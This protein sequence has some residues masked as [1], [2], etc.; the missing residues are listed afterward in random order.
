MNILKSL[1]DREVARERYDAELMADINQGTFPENQGKHYLYGK[2]YY[3]AIDKEYED[4]K[5]DLIFDL[6]KRFP[7]IHQIWKKE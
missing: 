4:R 1:S 2:V 6:K 7:E 3:D 5:L